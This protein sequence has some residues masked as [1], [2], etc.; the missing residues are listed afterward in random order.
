MSR[1][2]Q[3]I[4]GDYFNTLYAANPDPWQF[5]TSDYEREKYAAT[6]AALPRQRYRSG[7]EVGCSIGVL[8]HELAPRCE[9]LLALDIAD[10]ALETAR[11]RCSSLPHVEFRRAA[12]PDEWPDGTFDLILLSEIVYYLDTSDVRRLA[13]KALSSVVPGGHLLL[14][15][16]LGE[17]HYPLTGDEAAECFIERMRARAEPTHQARHKAYRL[18][19]LTSS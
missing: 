16:W 5:A 14:V 9:R 8:T 13:D 11:A 15:H 3:T 17:T 12:V 2:E 18:D 19:L 6:L 7:L 1:F 4:P 10:A